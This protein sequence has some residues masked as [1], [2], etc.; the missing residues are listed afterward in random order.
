[1]DKITVL[2]QTEG[3]YP[4]SSGGVSTWA[5]I[6][7]H[8][9]EN[10]INFVIMSI[11]GGVHVEPLYKLGNNIK[12]VIHVPLW[13]AVEP[14]EYYAPDIPFS[15]ELKKIY[16]INN[17]ILEN[18][19]LPL[20]DDFLEILFN[21]YNEVKLHAEILY[22]MWKYFQLYNYKN[23]LC[24]PLVW[25]L[26]KSK[27]YKSYSSYLGHSNTDSIKNFNFEDINNNKRMNVLNLQDIYLNIDKPAQ[28][29]TVFNLIFNLRWL[30]HFLL[31]LSIPLPDV[32]VTHSTIAGVA[33]IPSIIAKYEKGTPMI[34]TDHGVYIRERL[35]NVSASKLSFFAKKFLIDLA[36]VYTRATY[37]LADQISPVTSYNKKWEMLFEGKDKLIKVI[38]NGIDTNF[39]V[40]MEIK[41]KNNERPP[42]V[43][44]AARVF[45]LKD[46]LTMI[47]SCAIVKK[48]IPN[49]QYIIYGSLNADRLYVSECLQ[50]ISKLK[51]TENFKF[52][53]VHIN[54]PAIYNEGDISI[55]SSISEGF[56]YTVIES[57]SCGCPVVA[58]DV[59]GVREAVEGCGIVCNPKDY[60]SLGAA[61][62]KLLSDKDL[63]LKLGKKG[64]QKVL[65]YYTKEKSV[66]NYLKSY[67]NLNRLKSQP[68]KFNVSLESVKNIVEH[69]TEYE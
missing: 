37:Y 7:C 18:Y 35:I 60:K 55:L 67:K 31:P 30:Y 32:N 51:L 48:T 44:A 5:D 46:I 6:L 17:T 1:M 56:P 57:L 13:G 21:P 43:V 65:K 47:Q 14:S 15:N 33:S 28:R 50:L 45:P 11:T 42:T 24:D 66:K 16:R 36:T 26:F 53:G 3:T 10:D 58:T 39:F 4:Y 22:G 69:S 52:G 38:P 27:L 34:V 54:P 25:D 63:R 20:F 9:L 62:I 64:R 29:P 40:P 49:V 23:T 59:G 19:F 68:L 12:K 61:V 8:E 2:L 41:D